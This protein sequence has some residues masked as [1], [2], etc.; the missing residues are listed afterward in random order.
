M[1][2][3]AVLSVKVLVDAAQAASELEDVGD[4]AESMG[5][6]FGAIGAAIAGAGIV[7]ALGEAVAAASDLEQ[8]VGGTEAVFG[9]SAGQ[10]HDWAADTSDAIR[11][12]KTDFEKY[13]TSIGG[14]LKNADVPLDQLA[15][16][17]KEVLGTAAD[18]ASRWGTST[19]EA[20][21]AVNAA[22]SRGEFDSLE[23]Y[24][25]SI[26]AADV[27]TEKLALSTGSMAGA[28]DAALTAQARLNL[29]MEDSKDSIG[30]AAE[31]SG[32]FAAQQENLS[33]AFDNLLAAVGAPLLSA[34]GSF[35]A[36]IADTAG[37]IEPVLV[38]LASLVGWVLELPKPLLLA[39]GALV[40]WQV[41]GGLA[42]ITAAF[43]TAIKG[44]TVALKGLQASTVVGLA[45]VA[46]VTVMAAISDAFSGADE[47]IEQTTET[48]DRWLA[49]LDDGKV[50]EQT[51]AM[52]AT[53]SAASGL[54]DTYEKLG[55]S[56]G[57]YLDASTGVKGGAE[58]L[59][60]S[61]KT[62]TDALFKQGAVFG[63]VA[64]EAKA[65]G[66]AQSEIIAAA[67]SG[68]WTA[69]TAKMQT[70]ADAQSA[71]TG[72]ASTG[73]AIME[74]FTSALAAGVDPATALSTVTDLATQ[75]AD[76]FGVSADD[77]EQAARALGEA[78]AGAAP[79]VEELAGALEEV[80]TAAE[81]AARTTRLQA[82]LD[83]VG[84]AA[85]TAARD[86]EY[87]NTQIDA[88]TGRSASLDQA[89][90]AWAALLR[91]PDPDAVSE[92][93]AFFDAAANG[94]TIL[95]TFD[96]AALGS[97]AAGEALFGKL[98][99]LKGGYDT[100][101]SA[102]FESARQSGST[103][104]ALA[105]LAAQS[106]ASRDSFLTWAGPLA[107]AGVDIEALADKLG[108]L[109]LTTLSP[110]FLE[111]ITQDEDAQARLAALNAAQIDP[112]TITLVTDDLATPAVESAITYTDSATGKV[113][114]IPLDA[115]AKD[116]AAVVDAIVK[117][118]EGQRPDE[119]PI[120]ANAK[121]AE[122]VADKFTNEQ[123]KTKDV[124]VD[125]NTN[126]ARGALTSFIQSY[127]GATINFGVTVNTGPA[128]NAIAA[129]T[130]AYYQATIHVIADTSAFYSAFNALPSSK[131]VTAAP[132][133][134]PKFVA[135]TLARSGGR[136]S[137]PAPTSAGTIVNVS[138]F[139]GSED[140][141][142]RQ[143]DRVMTARV[144]RQRAVSV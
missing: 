57:A 56:T 77:A 66:I 9:D 19:G 94:V 55:V 79:G 128:S 138:G 46:I 134:A 54:F 17:T 36:L 129:V 51:R 47:A 16:K 1:A 73:V 32:S 96:T 110:K 20:V 85:D 86:L 58:A 83:A 107:A 15:G 8:A 106:A 28:S 135:P 143:I 82:T 74:A 90:V 29:I 10:I 27:A 124:T 123:R 45:L 109:D 68:D 31:E 78:G 44:L 97:T 14:A 11:L 24:N 93:Q 117:D 35:V 104:E 91:P 103:S 22:L 30:A 63:D 140:Q 6:K 60:R 115:D 3:S 12:S 137:A 21:E 98:T 70:Y 108:I 133:L 40:A 114:T 84:A 69:V 141:L 120:D 76:K 80:K 127:A 136:S 33:I 118:I 23:K 43:S 13:A 119:I 100:L 131:G 59:A 81:N 142:A 130:N 37:V 122:S 4:S 126:P 99:E 25:V 102:A 18:L 112:K 72:N 75:S 48:Y 95:N 139:V 52:I 64:D 50:T 101:N 89:S 26:T 7:A 65:A 87:I 2:R 125:A 105:A 53:E 38:A 34:V 88:L 49:T 113:R 39:V 41:V 116:A 67:A 71:L 62:A 92:T 42:G 5:S 144:R 61:V 121:A 111:V 132:K